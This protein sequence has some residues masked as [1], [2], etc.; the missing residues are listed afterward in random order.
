MCNR[1]DPLNNQSAKK[2]ILPRPSSTTNLSTITQLIK[3]NKLS[4]QSLG[5]HLLNHVNKIYKSRTFFFFF[6]KWKAG[7]SIGQKV[8][9]D[10]S[11]SMTMCTEYSRKHQ[12]CIEMKYTLRQLKWHKTSKLRRLVQREN[13]RNPKC[14]KQRHENLWS[15]KHGWHCPK[16]NAQMYVFDQID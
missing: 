8:I 9:R 4:K 15:D 13:W 2:K 5:N 3:S 14:G 1:F 11:S 12:T 10:N 7:A 16:N 6:S